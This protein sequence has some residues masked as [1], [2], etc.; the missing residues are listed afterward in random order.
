MIPTKSTIRARVIE[1]EL[2]GRY[3]SRY[4]I[5]REAVESAPNAKTEETPQLEGGF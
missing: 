3:Y 5:P 1:P 2:R 4:C